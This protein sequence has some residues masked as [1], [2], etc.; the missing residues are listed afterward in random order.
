MKHPLPYKDLV[1]HYV[2]RATRRTTAILVPIYVIIFMIGYIA[3][4][5]RSFDIRFIVISILLFVACIMTMYAV[6]SIC[7]FDAFGCDRVALLK[8]RSHAYVICEKC[9]YP[10]DKLPDG[11]GI[12]PECGVEYNKKALKFKWKFIWL[13]RSVGL[14]KTKELDFAK[15]CNPFDD[16]DDC[17]KNML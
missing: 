9:L 17:D 6:H 16:I 4:E 11:Q 12:C 3:T 1:P 13:K 5:G 15:Y 10:I 7:I 2:Q 8:S 14:R